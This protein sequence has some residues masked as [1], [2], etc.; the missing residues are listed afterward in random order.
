MT[1]SGNGIQREIKV[2]GQKLNTVMSFNFL[3]AFVSDDG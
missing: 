2:K 1:S 3:G